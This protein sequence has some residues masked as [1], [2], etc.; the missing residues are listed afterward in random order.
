MKYRFRLCLATLTIGF[1]VMYFAPAARAQQ[2]EQQR[3]TPSPSEVQPPQTPS[4]TP[5]TG[6]QGYIKQN[7]NDSNT[8]S[9]LPETQ[10]RATFSWGTLIFGFIIGGLVGYLIGRQPRTPE[11]RRDRAA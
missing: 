11:A 3:A 8:P 2:Q 4:E 5:A 1:A 10:P 9:T 6:E 7:Q